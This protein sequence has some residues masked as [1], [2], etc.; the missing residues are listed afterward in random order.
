MPGLCQ[1]PRWWPPHAGGPGHLWGDHVDHI[2]IQNFRLTDAGGQ[3][4]NGQPGQWIPS[5]GFLY[6]LGNEANKV[7]VFAL[8]DHGPFPCESFEYEVFVTD[9]LNA[10]EIADP[11]KELHRSGAGQWSASTG[12]PTGTVGIT[13]PHRW[14]RA[15]L[16]KA[17]L[18]AGTISPCPTAGIDG[19][20]MAGIELPRRCLRHGL[21]IALRDHL[22]VRVAGTRQAGN[23]S[24]QCQ[25]FSNEYELDAVAGLQPDESAICPDADHDGYASCACTPPGVVC[26]CDDNDPTVHPGA[27]EDCSST[28]DYACLGH[29]PT[30][31]SGYDC[32]TQVD[33]GF[34]TDAGPGASEGVHECL[35]RCTGGELSCPA[36]GSCQGGHCIT[37]GC[38]GVVCGAN[39][40]CVSGACLDPCMGANCPPG[41]DCESGQCIDLC[42]TVA[43][44]QG[45][46]CSHGICEPGC[47]CD[48]EV[49]TGG[50][51]CADDGGFCVDP[52]CAQ[53]S[54]PAS[55]ECISGGCVDICSVTTCPLL[56][57]CDAGVCGVDACLTVVCDGGVCLNGACTDAC[58]AAGNPCSA[59]QVCVGG[60]A[61]AAT[62][63]TREPAE[64][65]EL[66]PPRA[67]P[68][69]ARSGEPG[70]RAPD[71]TRPMVETW[72]R[73]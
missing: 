23:P 11:A 66:T 20:R 69:V 32:V 34:V 73:R 4:S 60:S 38:S 42:R 14:N 31:P 28:K 10:T 13:D 51:V 61:R 40:V 46:L 22:P 43:C 49:C 65:Q 55:Q 6:D 37:G 35:A 12:H 52:D 53:V 26:D 56:T 19:T 9:D 7:A 30:C 29:L 21:L 63:A 15:V 59:N 8:T 5:I 72:D 50:Q 64:R 36:G 47:G 48:P 58:T 18:A 33:G 2:A 27:P 1:L 39:Q 62:E 24:P 16:Y 44:P 3:T 57:T 41:L 45:Q 54:C 68:V 17:F 71:R 70:R 25:F 67:L